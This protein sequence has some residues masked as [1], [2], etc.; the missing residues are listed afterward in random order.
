[1]R[2]ADVAVRSGVRGAG[3]LRARLV[4]VM[5]LRLEKIPGSENIEA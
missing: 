2:T 1:M 3:V 5:C 4:G